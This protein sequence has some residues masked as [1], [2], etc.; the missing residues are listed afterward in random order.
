MHGYESLKTEKE[1]LQYYIIKARTDFRT[2]FLL[3]ASIVASGNYIEST[4]HTDFLC[5]ICQLK[6]DKKLKNLDLGISIP[7][8]HTK[9]IITNVLFSAWCLGNNPRLRILVGTNSQGEGNKR[10]MDVRMLMQSS[11]YKRIFPDVELVNEEKTWLTTNYGGGRRA[12]TTNI[13]MNIT[14]GDADLLIADDPNDA[15]STPLDLQNCIDWYAIKARSRSRIALKLSESADMQDNNLGLLLIQQ[16]IAQNDL[17]GYM[18]ENNKNFFH[19]VLKAEEEEDV[20]YS[21]PL[22]DGK[23]LYIKRKAGYLWSRVYD[24]YYSP[25]KNATNQSVW[26]RQYQQDVL[27]L[28]DDA[29]FKLTRDNYVDPIVINDQSYDFTIISVDCASS[30]SSTADNTAFVYMGYRRDTATF[31]VIDVIKGKWEY[32]QI[33][34]QFRH[35][36]AKCDKLKRVSIVAIEAASSGTSL[37]SLLNSRS[38]KHPDTG[39]SII[40]SFA[41]EL[42]K[43]RASKQ[44]RCELATK[45]SGMRIKLPTHAEWLSSYV[46]ELTSF[47]HGKNDDM[48]DATTQGI[49][50]LMEKLDGKRLR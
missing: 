50:V 18:L 12:V 25:V 10:N 22:I 34:E 44:A 46:S 3:C 24:T 36:Y 4:F 14:G 48:V 45:V 39:Y 1:K 7:P 5:L 13:A 6:F 31:Y 29:L 20:E 38:L 32:E 9:T 41:T 2:F 17:T 11:I 42:F 26:L 49:I 16:R 35:F 30:S 47:P 15:N 43:A 33:E 8:G 21:I 23:Y 19:L 27:S 28:S 37:F 40:P